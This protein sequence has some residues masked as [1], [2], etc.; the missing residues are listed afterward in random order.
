MP[1]V[2]Q[3]LIQTDKQLYQAEDLIRF[4]LF[5]L[6]ADTRPV[7]VLGS[8]VVKII[9]RQGFIMT[10]F[11]NVTFVKGRFAGDFQL[12]IIVPTGTWIIRVQVDKEVRK[13]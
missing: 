2:F 6:D 7:N 8:T 3:I 4:R 5:A 12:G 9:N 10:Q 13:N 1:Q 11:D